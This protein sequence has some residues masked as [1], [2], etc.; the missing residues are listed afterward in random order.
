MSAVFTRRMTRPIVFSSLSA[1]RPRLMVCALLAW[2]KPV[3]VPPVPMPGS[4]VTLPSV[5]VTIRSAP[6]VLFF[7]V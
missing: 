5:L 4:N 3:P 6:Y 2:K 1:G 7:G